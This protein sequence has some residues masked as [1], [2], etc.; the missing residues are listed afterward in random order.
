MGE[1]KYEGCKFFQTGGCRVE[2]FPQLESSVPEFC[3][4]YKSTTATLEL[5]C[6]CGTDFV[7]EPE[8][9]RREYPVCPKCRTQAHFYYMRDRVMK[10]EADLKKIRAAFIGVG[11]SGEELSE[12]DV[13]K[14]INEAIK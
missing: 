5:K 11:Y 10:A 4:R 9:G 14:V 2:V 6:E 3:E 7:F 13:D 8:S 1:C 12:K